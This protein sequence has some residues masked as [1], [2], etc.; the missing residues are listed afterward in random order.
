VNIGGEDFEFMVD[1]GAMVSVVQPGV[2]KARVQPCDVRATCV[3]G[4]QLEIL[5]EQEIEITLRNEGYGVSR[6]HM[7]LVCPLVRCSC[8][9]LG[10]DFFKRV[11][12]QISLTA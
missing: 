10:M 1:T 8:G 9:I 2:S 7:F 12:T 4:T 6:V 3:T 11:E 5:G